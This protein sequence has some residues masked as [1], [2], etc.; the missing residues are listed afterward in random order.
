MNTQSLN[1]LNAFDMVFRS[2]VHNGTSR[3][4]K[5]AF[6]KALTG[7]GGTDEA[8]LTGGSAIR[9]QSLD[10]LMK[11]VLPQQRDFTMWQ[12]LPKRN[13]WSMVDYYNRYTDLGGWPGATVN[14]ETGTLMNFNPTIARA[15]LP[16]AFF[17]SKGSV[18]VMLENAKSTEDPLMLEQRRTLISC[19]RD[20]EIMSLY[21]NR[22][23]YALQP[24]GILH[25]MDT[26]APT[27]VKNVDGR[28]ITWDDV[29]EGASDVRGQ[30][31]F[32][33]VDTSVMSNR[34]VFDWQTSTKDL[35]RVNMEVLSKTGNVAVNYAVDGIKSVYG[36]ILNYTDIYLTEDK[37][38][39]TSEYSTYTN[40]NASL[41]PAVPAGLAAVAAADAN[42]RF[43]QVS[44]A[45]SYHYLVYG[46]NDYG[47]GPAIITAAAVAVAVGDAV[48]LTI[49]PSVTNRETAYEVFRSRKLAA[50]AAAPAQSDFRKI[51]TVVKTA[52]ATTYVDRNTN[53]PGTSEVILLSKDT[54]DA[55]DMTVFAEPF[56]YNLFS[57]DQLVKLF[58]TALACALRVTKPEMHWVIK[59]V[60]P[61]RATW[62]PFG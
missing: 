54:K 27:N 11:E 41:S 17:T 23:A 56:Q 13:I 51:G 50:G 29:V 30:R 43:L 57:S 5:E 16:M 15:T 48:T 36:E 61:S 20:A 55:I 8:A 10:P 12:I 42:S 14:S 9:I 40:Y 25:T 3:A 52:G 1:M 2:N 46:Q 22:D 44:Q 60:L 26:G 19:L 39:Y 7:F 62:R 37:V 31:R 24:N 38:P 53:I 58:A 35:N 33:Q 4:G 34:C 6:F 45:G 18:S 32:G 47:W 59:N 49:A 21:G 28:A